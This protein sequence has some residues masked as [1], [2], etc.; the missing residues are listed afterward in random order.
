MGESGAVPLRDED[1]ERGAVG[2]V[3]G[4]P[5]SGRSL[6]GRLTPSDFA[7]EHWREAWVSLQ[8]VP[9]P[10]LAAVRSDLSDRGKLDLLGLSRL[11]GATEAVP[12]PTAEFCDHV[13]ERLTLLR[14]ARGLDAVLGRARSDLHANPSLLDD[15][16]V[17]HLVERATEAQGEA[18]PGA[19]RGVVSMEQALDELVASLAEG[20]HERLNIGIPLIDRAT[21]G[22]EPGELFIDLGRTDSLK[23]MCYLNRLRSMA[24]RYPDRSWLVAN[25]EMPRRQTLMRLLRMETERASNRDVERAITEGGVDLDV[26]NDRFR[27]VY[28]LDR[29]RVTLAEIAAQGERI[30]RA[31]G[32]LLGVV[33]DHA[34]LV[35]SERAAGS[36]YEHAS[37]VAVGLKQLARRLEAVVFAVVQANR[38]GKSGAD[39][40][41]LESA[42]D[43]G[44]FEENADFTLAYSGINQ[45]AGAL[46]FV[47]V[48]LAKNRCCR[49]CKTA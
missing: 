13:V 2:V 37:A 35:R 39:P 10:E 20:T 48:E 4:W 44:A 21:G 27:H 19:L 24:Q 25:L 5:D 43:S 46:P 12:R 16:L 45:P 23:T 36:A 18:G 49:S 30:K 9:A 14:R 47:K 6:L 1:L 22:V 41:A 38:A 29:G 15:G 26:F 17:P 32:S 42:R 28:F 8:R 7:C 40:V 31:T 11:T 34:G 3:L 33:V